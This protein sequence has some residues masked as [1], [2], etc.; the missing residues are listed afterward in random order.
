[1]C[2]VSPIPTHF[3]WLAVLGIVV[4]LFFQCVATLLDPAN[5]RKEGIKRWGLI[6]YTV[7]MFSFVTVY[8]GMGSDILSI[9]FIDNRGFQGVGDTIPPGPIG[10]QYS[11]YPDAISLIPNIMFLFN[12]WLADGLLARFSLTRSPRGLT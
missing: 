5:R 10:Y 7:V 11:I 1:M 6:A 12:N 9:S 3:V 2:F 4:V 8:T